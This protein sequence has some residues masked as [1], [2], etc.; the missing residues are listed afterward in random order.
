MKIV[1][2]VVVVAVSIGMSGCAT[3]SPE[4]RAKLDSISN[5]PTPTCSGEL[6]QE[7]WSR[8][9]IWI[10]QNARMKIQIATDSVLQTYNPNNDPVYAMTA[11]KE[12]LG[13]GKYR[14]ELALVCGNI[15][16]CT[17]KPEDVRNIFYHYVNTGED[18]AKYFRN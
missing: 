18:F 6:C 12:A 5:E 9:Q 16:G 11:T 17:S 15:F 7:M 10:A 4:I 14:V 2:I 8:A 13:A 1:N 3:M